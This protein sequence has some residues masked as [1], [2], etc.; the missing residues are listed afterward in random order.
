MW[1][2]V[3]P[4]GQPSDTP[5][6]KKPNSN[7]PGLTR[8]SLQL[9]N[10]ALRETIGSGHSRFAAPLF[11][12]FLLNRFVHLSAHVM[13]ALRADDMRHHSRRTLRAVGILFRLQNVVGTPGTRPSV[14][15]SAFWNCHTLISLRSR[16]SKINFCRMAK[17]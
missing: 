17:S 16:N 9:I 7:L 4:L 13:A 1:V 10:G 8:L 12:L 15:L 2:D 6:L 3:E 11:F 14:R 5:S